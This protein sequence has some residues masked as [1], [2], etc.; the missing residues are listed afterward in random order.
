MTEAKDTA[1]TTDYVMSLI[2]SNPLRLEAIKAVVGA[3]LLSQAEI[4]FK[5]GYMEGYPD[6]F[7][8]GGKVG[9]GE[10]VKEIGLHCYIWY[11][12]DNKKHV[13]IDMESWQ[14]KLKEWGIKK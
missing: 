14:A 8:D 5:G 4:T 13:S 11:D 10:V 1:I 9:R 6:G 7:Q 3:Q 2:E 12:E